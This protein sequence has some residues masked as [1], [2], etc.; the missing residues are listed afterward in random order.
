MTIA[1]ASIIGGAVANVFAFTDSQV[2][3]RILGGDGGSMEEVK[4]HNSEKLQN[5]QAEYNKKREDAI[6]KLNVRL[7]VDCAATRRLDDYDEA[8]RL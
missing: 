3:A 6:D 4:R 2:A 5:P 8:S 1:I 7:A